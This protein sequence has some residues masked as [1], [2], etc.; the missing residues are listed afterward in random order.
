MKRLTA[1]LLTAAVLTATPVLATEFATEVPVGIQR[2]VAHPDKSSLVFT[3][4]QEGAEFAGRFHKFSVSL[5]T[6]PTADDVA[7]LAISSVIQLGSVDTQYQDRDD[8][9]VQEDWFNVDVWPEARFVSTTITATGDGHFVADG[10]LS[11]RGVSQAVAVTLAL[12]ME[13]NGERGTLRGSA[14]LN[15]LEFGVGQGDWASTEWVGDAVEVEF[16]LYILRAYE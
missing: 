11:M 1:F 5:E 9:L 14:Q 12:T 13:D 6:H 7:L 16:D 8:T 10:E 3:A 15:R 4:T 2:W